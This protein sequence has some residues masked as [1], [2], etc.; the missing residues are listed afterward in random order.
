MEY[1]TVKYRTDFIQQSFSLPCFVTSFVQSCILLPNEF[2]IAAFVVFNITAILN[3]ITRPTLPKKSNGV[4]SVFI[5]LWLKLLQDGTRENNTVQ[6]LETEKWKIELRSNK[7]RATAKRKLL[8]YAFW[9]ANHPTSPDLTQK[10]IILWS[11]KTKKSGKSELNSKLNWTK[12]S[13]N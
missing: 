3:C 2:D 12:F 6:I 8:L 9:L 5:H 10:M 7:N 11:V 1:S 13:F 4:Y